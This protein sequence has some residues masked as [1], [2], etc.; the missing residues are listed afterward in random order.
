MEKILESQLQNIKFLEEFYVGLKTVTEEALTK[1]L[2]DVKL[3]VVMDLWDNIY[4]ANT[5]VMES[6]NIDVPINI[7]EFLSNKY[8]EAF[9]IFD[10]SVVLIFLY[11]DLLNTQGSIQSVHISE[12]VKVIE[13][14]QSYTQ[15]IYHSD[16]HTRNNSNRLQLNENIPDPTS[17]SAGQD[18]HSETINETISVW[19]EAKYV[20]LM[21]EPL[22][23]QSTKPLHR[24]QINQPLATNRIE[25]FPFKAAACKSPFFKFGSN[26]NGTII[27]SSAYSG[28][29]LE[30]TGNL[31]IK[32]L[33]S[34]WPIKR[35]SVVELMNVLGVGKTNSKLSN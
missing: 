22:P 10:A 16:S 19:S 27:S 17:V 25:N 12:T 24:I 32:S 4:D 14:Q 20:N 34:W 5:T 23:L 26:G 2:L 33:L 18:L 11:L 1:K 30:N 9:N 13:Q 29:R 3:K 28:H 35:N 7:K 6:T 31:F 21:E 15:S 8:D